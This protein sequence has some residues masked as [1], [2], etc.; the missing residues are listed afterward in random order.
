MKSNL[1]KIK[2]AVMKMKIRK[3][4]KMIEMSCRQKHRILKMHKNPDKNE[5]C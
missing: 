4:Q 3:C 2:I 5:K 1:N